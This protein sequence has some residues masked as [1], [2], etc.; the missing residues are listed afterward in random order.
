[1]L[2]SQG[3]TLAKQAFESIP[4]LSALTKS[5][6][7]DL[8]DL[9]G[10]MKIVLLLFRAGK[11]EFSILPFLPKLWSLRTG[12]KGPLNDKCRDSGSLGFQIVSPRKSHLSLL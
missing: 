4:D 1:V 5:V 9:I 11:A 7:H 10:Q 6:F 2:S 3:I 12:M 8:D